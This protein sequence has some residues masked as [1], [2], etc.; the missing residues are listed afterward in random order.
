MANKKHLN[1]LILKANLS[2]DIQ[3]ERSFGTL[4]NLKSYSWTVK[5]PLLKPLRGG[6]ISNAYHT[7]Q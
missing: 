4:S 6:H 3:D 1:T 2:V 7:L 5:Q